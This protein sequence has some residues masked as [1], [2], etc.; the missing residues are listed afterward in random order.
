MVPSLPVNFG[1]A[2]AARRGQR[3]LAV[4]SAARF[5]MERCAKS[6]S[7]AAE[8]AAALR[9]AT[10]HDAPVGFRVESVLRPELRC[11]C[12]LPILASWRSRKSS[13]EKRSEGFH[14][15]QEE[16]IHGFDRGAPGRRRHGDEKK[17]VHPR[18]FRETMRA[19]PWK[20]GARHHPVT[21][22]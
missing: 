10:V 16:K 12:L 19:R 5:R 4:G 2:D 17:S 14:K 3:K 20:Q 8:R 15:L 18:R 11:V 21:T 9:F 13:V 7:Y 6:S 1:S 22:S